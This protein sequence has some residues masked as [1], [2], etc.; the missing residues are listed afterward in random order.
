MIALEILGVTASSKT[1]LKPLNLTG[2]TFYSIP[3]FLFH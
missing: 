1:Y 3:Y 2:R